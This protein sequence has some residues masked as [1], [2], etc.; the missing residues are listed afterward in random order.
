MPNGLNTDVVRGDE[1]LAS[2][3]ARQVSGTI[4]VGVNDTVLALT[5][6]ATLGDGFYDGQ[7]LAIYTKGTTYDALKLTISRYSTGLSAAAPIEKDIELYCGFTHLVYDSTFTCWKEIIIQNAIKAKEA[8]NATYAAYATSLANIEITTPSDN[9]A[10][11]AGKINQG[12][13]LWLNQIIAKINGLFTQM[14]SK[15]TLPSGGTAGQY[16]NGQGNLATMPSTPEYT[17]QV[18]STDIG[19]T[20]ANSF[21]AAGQSIRLSTNTRLV[22]LVVTRTASLAISIPLNAVTAITPGSLAA[23]YRPASSITVPVTL[24]GEGNAIG[25]YYSGYV[26][27]NTAGAMILYIRNNYNA[28]STPTFNRISFTA[29]FLTSSLS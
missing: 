8:I 4:T 13:P 29:T 9:T 21:S 2:L 19:Y 22:T 28:T 14:A 17:T 18:V 23:G 11:F 12:L 15:F 24:S 26:I 7:Q 16:I 27:I 3:V 10:K 1:S 6:N 5:A 20:V 25:V